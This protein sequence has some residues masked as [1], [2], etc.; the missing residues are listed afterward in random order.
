MTVTC[1]DGHASTADDYCDV[2]G[3]PIAAAATP[4]GPAGPDSAPAAEAAPPAAAEELVCPNCSVPNPSEALFCEACGYDFTTGTMPRSA[5][6]GSADG[7]DS[8]G[9]EVDGPDASSDD[10]SAG[11]SADGSS[12]DATQGAGPTSESVDTDF[13]WVAEIWIDP[14]WYAV[15]QSPDPLPSPGPPEIVPLRGTSLL[16]GRTSRSRNIHPDLP[17]ENDTGVSRRQAQLTTDGSRWWIEDLD[18]S[19]GT[20]VGSPGEPLPEVPIPVGPRL[21]LDGDDRIYVGAWTRIVIRKATDDEKA[22]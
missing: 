5:D 8:T 19:N 2:C 14:D 11:S 7:G 21:E 12:A 4:E 9:A 22:G 10:G 15:Q 6:S 18:S 1:P 3:A 20:F 13:D 16:I 17:C